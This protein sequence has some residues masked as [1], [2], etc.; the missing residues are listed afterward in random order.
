MAGT[1][2]FVHVLIPVNISGSSLPSQNSR[3]I[4]VT[5]NEVGYRK[6][7]EKDKKKP[8]HKPGLFY[9]IDNL[10]N[11]MLLDSEGI[12]QTIASLLPTLPRVDEAPNSL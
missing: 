1:I 6:C 10:I 9:Q 7:K 4:S 3:K 5:S 12:L 2:I 8:D 11:F